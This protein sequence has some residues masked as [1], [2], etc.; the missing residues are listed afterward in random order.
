M[1]NIWC[2]A[3]WKEDDQEEEGVIPSVWVKEN[4]V[5]WPRGVNVLKAM[6][7]MRHPDDSWIKFDL[8]KLKFSSAKKKE[9]EQYNL[10]TTAEF[11][12][13]D[14]DEPAR[15][16]RKRKT[17]DDFVTGSGM[18]QT[19]GSC[20]HEESQTQKKPN[21]SGL[22]KPP[23]QP[24][25]KRTSALSADIDCDKSG[26]S[27]SVSSSDSRASSAEPV[28]QILNQ[29]PL[30]RSPR[31]QI[32]PRRLQ[33]PSPLKQKQSL[34]HGQSKRKQVESRRLV[35]PSPLSQ[36]QSLSHPSL[37]TGLDHQ[38]S[39]GDSDIEEEL[40]QLQTR[41][42]AQS[43]SKRSSGY[44]MST[45]RFQRRVIQLLVEIRD[46]VRQG[47]SD[48][49]S[50]TDDRDTF[51][52]REIDSL[53]D[54]L[55]FEFSLLDPEVQ[56]KMKAQMRTVGGVT[57]GDHVKNAMKKCM[58]NGLMAKMNMKRKK[59]KFA[60]VSTTV[61]KLIKESIIQSHQDATEAKVL[62]EM[63][64][65]LKYAPGRIGGGGRVK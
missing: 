53:E 36:Q 33:Q 61:C 47:N 19:S 21:N 57:I 63:G 42:D 56:A 58:T 27:L 12:S 41:K 26:S 28:R 52:I 48:G 51:V 44:P 7:E 60:F 1:E 9:C 20:A 11:S 45:E 29:S 31:K 24:P 64:R 17:Y 49:R 2:R 34:T 10:T 65:F 14:E 59:G 4:T 35:Q 23:Q 15:R 16:Q 50:M 40:P 62:D 25:K 5:M 22:S 38:E 55:Q 54:F 37:R 8:V 43:Q 30:R 32:E 13:S 46:Q 39:S 6:K 18:E 3:V